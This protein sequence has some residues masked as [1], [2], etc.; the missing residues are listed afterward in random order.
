VLDTSAGEECDDGNNLDGD[1]CSAM[2][3]REVCVL[4]SASWSKQQA[5]EGEDV[6]L[7]VEGVGCDGEEISFAVWEY[8]TTSADDPVVTNPSNVVFS[9]TTA[10]GTWTA[11]WQADASGDP[12]YYFIGTVVG[13][14]EE[15]ETDKDT[16]SLLHVSLLPVE[17][18]SSVAI[19][20]DYGDEGSCVLDRCDV[21]ENSLQGTVD[22]G[23][24]NITCACEWDTT[25]NECDAVW[26]VVDPVTGEGVG[27]CTYTQTSDDTCEDDGFLTFSWTAVWTPD[28]ECDATCQAENADKEAACTDGQKTVECPA[29]IL[30][31]FF[32]AY[33][34]IIALIIIG[35]IYWA[36]SVEKGKS[37][38]KRKGE[39]K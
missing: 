12:E 31:P 25:A 35:L 19:C 39:K 26:G 13:T 15:I 3:E 7:I 8:D 22:C 29:Q 9:G 23:E 24:D 17:E 5:V 33:N 11:E 36:I 16:G 37:R 32:D 28:P 27:K 4:T 30:L 6:D 21:A 1:G 34:V 18:C 10:T 20:A 14:S 38:K 2:C